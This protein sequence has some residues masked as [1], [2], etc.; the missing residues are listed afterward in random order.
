[1]PP[2]SVYI[3][4]DVACAAGKRLPICVVSAGHPLMPLKIPKPFAGLIPRGVGNKEIAAFT[5][6][7]A[8]AREV[9][10]AINRIAAE[11]RWRVERIAVDAPAAPPR[12]GSRESESELGRLGLSSFRTPAASAWEG[13]RERCANHLR[14]GGSATTLP[15][16][17]KIWM[18]FGFELFAS[19][20]SGLQAEVIEVYPFAIVWALLPTCEHKSTEQGY[21]RQLA[22]VAARTGWE[23][24]HLEARL[25]KTVPGSRHDR[26]DSFMAAWVASLPPEQ[27]RTFGDAQRP[28]DAIW[29]P[30]GGARSV[31]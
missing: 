19:L 1:M 12:T 15:H 5:P 27:R 16:A 11:M 10:S 20:K 23:P 14:L 28:D 7:R 9:V 31:S 24:E 29:V 26:L 2:S 18:L 22:A 21:R 8:A 3:G 13:I 6:F 25:K 17:N 30:S 4:I